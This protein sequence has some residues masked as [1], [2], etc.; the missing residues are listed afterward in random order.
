MNKRHP[1]S[2]TKHVDPDTGLIYF[3]YDFGYE[4]GIVFPGEGKHAVT[5]SSQNYKG[6]RKPGDIEVPIT[7][8][9]SRK[10]NGYAKPASQNYCNTFPR[11]SATKFNKTVKWEPTSESEFSE[12]E[13]VRKVVKNDFASNQ[14]SAPPNLYIP[15]SPSPRWDPTSPSPAS[16]SPSFPSLSPRYGGAPS[17]VDSTPG[18]APQTPTT[19]MIANMNNEMRKCRF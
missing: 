8:E 17:N 1:N 14:T 3:K 6:Q 9:F 18:T 13:E 4:F 19:L 15:N 11:K 16:L 10:E 5:S 7:H 2:G 12:A